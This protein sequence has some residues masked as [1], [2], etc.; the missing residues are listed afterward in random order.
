LAQR[1]HGEKDGGTCVVTM[2][3]RF[4]I[5]IED[6][7]KPVFGEGRRRLLVAVHQWGSINRAAFELGQPYRKA[8]ASLTAMEQRLGF[9]LLDRRAGGECGGGTCLTKRGLD[10][11]RHYGELMQELQLLAGQK[12]GL[13]FD[14]RYAESHSHA[15]EKYYSGVNDDSGSRIDHQ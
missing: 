4:K 11:L 6:K 15:G 3:I 10:F 1:S 12:S 5:W 8:W 7:G 9:R 13:L 14:E 2:E